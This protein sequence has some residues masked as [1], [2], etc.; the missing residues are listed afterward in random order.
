M[1]LTIETLEDA[2]HAWVLEVSGLPEARVIFSHQDGPEPA[3]AP[4]LTITVAESFE[5]LGMYPEELVNGSGVAYTVEHWRIEGSL[6][7]W[8][9]GARQLIAT[10]KSKCL[11]P[12]FYKLLSDLGIDADPGGLTFIP[13]VKNRGW[14]EHAKL[15]MIFRLRD[16]TTT[17]TGAA[18]QVGYFETIG[19]TLPDL[20][21][22]PV[23]DPITV[24][25]AD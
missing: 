8:G 4:Y 1:A 2:V 6:D 12:S 16:Q 11:L 5:T 23:D 15:E 9:A 18:E 10:V 13:A 21:P 24:E 14:E 7:A 19:Y 3:T 25:A 22:H 20:D 17:D